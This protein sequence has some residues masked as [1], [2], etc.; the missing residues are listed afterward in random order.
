M[1]AAA[2]EEYPEIVQQELDMKCVPSCTICHEHSG[3]GIGSLNRG[4]SEDGDTFAESITNVLFGQPGELHDKTPENV[5]PALRAL[6]ALGLDCSDVDPRAC[7]D[8]D[9]DGIND[10]AELREGRDPNTPGAGNLCA[11]YGCGARVEPRGRL[12]AWGFVAAAL[13]A[14]LLGAAY[15]RRT[16]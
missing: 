15:R 10:V 12:D 3:G 2:S 6:E 5:A 14:L 1:P 8:S 7:G 4:T 16:N 11:D 9:E 13:S